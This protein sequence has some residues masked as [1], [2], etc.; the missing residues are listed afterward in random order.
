MERQLRGFERLVSCFKVIYSYVYLREENPVIVSVTPPIWQF[1]VFFPTSTFCFTP[2]NTL[3]PFLYV[4]TRLSCL[5]FCSSI[6]PL[7]SLLTQCSWFSAFDTDVPNQWYSHYFNLRTQQLYLSVQLKMY[8]LLISWSQDIWKRYCLY[9][10]NLLITGHLKVSGF[11]PF[12]HVDW[13]EVHLIWFWQPLCFTRC[14][15]DSLLCG[16][17]LLLFLWC[18]AT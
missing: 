3:N 8:F 13:A 10:F 18:A 4:K 12:S 9:E 11:V 16:R 14:S 5:C 1:S 6:L 17:L 15:S 2:F 7:P